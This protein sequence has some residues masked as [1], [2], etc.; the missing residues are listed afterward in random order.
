MR[1]ASKLKPR[2]AIFLSGRGSNARAL[3]ELKNEIDIALVVSSKKSAL[4][5]WRLKQMGFNTHWLSYPISYQALDDSLR[6]EKIDYV[7]LLGFMKILPAGFLE[8]W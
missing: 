3:V 5:L 8:K 7:F 4:G 1:Q 2:W 6:A